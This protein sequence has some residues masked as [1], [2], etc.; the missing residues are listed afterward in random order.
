MLPKSCGVYRHPNPRGQ[1]VRLTALV[2]ER[3]HRI[4]GRLEEETGSVPD[5]CERCG[6]PTMAGC[7][8]CNSRI[9]GEWSNVYEASSVPPPLH[10]TG[11]GRAFPWRAAALERARRVSEMEAEIRGFDQ[12]TREQ[13]AAFTELVAEERATP[14]EASTFGQWFRQK[15]GPEA[16]RT[17]GGVLKD[18]ATSAIADIIRKTMMGP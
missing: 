14:D 13:L 3:G 11:C 12:Q 15:A 4:T 5:F 8:H 9:L 18:A 16:A 2:C 1:D 7:L 6:A 10:C 17:I